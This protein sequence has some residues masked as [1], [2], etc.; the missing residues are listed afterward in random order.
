MDADHDA[1]VPDAP[2]RLSATQLRA[3]REL[4]RPRGRAKAGQFLAEGPQAVRE[5]LA[6]GVVGWLVVTDDAAARDTIAS[7]L[8]V[9]TDAGVVVHRAEPTQMMQFT[10]TVHGQGLVAVCR[11]PGVRLDDVPAPRLVVVADQVRDPGNLGTLIRNADAFG[12]DAV[13]LTPGCVEPWN[14]KVVRASVGS[15]FHVPLAVD[16]PLSEAVGWL[17]AHGVEVLAAD[18]GGEPLDELAREGG[19][20]GPAA[21]VVGNEAWGLSPADVALCDRVVSVPMGGRAESLNVAS[22]SAVCLYVTA[23]E[24]RRD[25]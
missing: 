21:W 9:A 24:Q 13:V 22:A 8:D 10:D 15:L 2:A 7:M 17:R 11:M 25:P 20:A 16:V 5:A 18:A 3:M 12:A 19:L 1:G 6:A 4:V 23:Q 14:P